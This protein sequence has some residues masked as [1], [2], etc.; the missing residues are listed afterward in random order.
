[1]TTLVRPPLGHE[2]KVGANL[3]VLECGVC[4]CLHG[5]PA[6]WERMAEKAGHHEYDWY[7]PQGHKIGYGGS[8]DLEKA[9]KRAEEA[10]RRVQ[11]E[12]D[13]RQDTERRLIAQRGETT[14]AR[15]R[16]A[17]AVCPCCNRTFQQLARHM[18]TKHPDYDPAK[19]PA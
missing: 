12:R 4:G 11:A 6:A 14:K 8:S 18:K 16:A 3:T 17:A 1:M 7:C 15:K 13:L 10:E 5:I 19:P 2:F 9:R